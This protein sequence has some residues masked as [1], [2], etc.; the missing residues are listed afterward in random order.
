[1]VGVRNSRVVVVGGGVMGAA[2]TWALARRGVEV[3]LLERFERGHDGGASHGATRNF[4]TAYHQPHYLDLVLRARTLW[5]ELAQ[6]SGQTVL[7]PVGLIN[8]GGGE[9]RW[10][11]AAAALHARGEQVQWLSAAAAAERWPALRFRAARESAERGR[12]VLWVPGGA[13][14][15]ASAALAAMYDGAAHH[16]A[17]LRF[18]TPVVR[19]ESASGTGGAVVVTHQEEVSAAVVIL[20]AGAWTSQLAAGLLTLPPLA[21]SQESPVHAA[22]VDPALVA[23]A[24][25]P[26]FNHA[27]DPGERSDDA[28]LADIYGMLTPGEGLKVGWH[29]GGP[30][31]DPDARSF[32]PDAGQL[33]ALRRYL[34]QWVPGA[35]PDRLSPI[36]CT[37]TST[38]TTDFVLDRRGPIVVGA[39]FSGHGFK[40][41]PAIGEVLARLALGE[42]AAADPFRL[43]AR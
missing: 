17:D 15:R 34:A 11:R 2:A 12:E 25:L 31:T 28:F 33:R 30:R 13:R 8:H 1:M 23:G 27:A 41:A 19:I 37:Y 9:R 43:A 18:A 14:I 3:V 22:V 39:G 42:R 6:E 21:V 7:D 38:P 5:Q 29:G 35:D 24:E 36:S 40:F 26:G 20:T 16:G 4:N 10:G 32:L